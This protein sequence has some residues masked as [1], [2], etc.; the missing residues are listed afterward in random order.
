M[1]FEYLKY[2]KTQTEFKYTYYKDTFVSKVMHSTQENFS[3]CV[4][5]QYIQLLLN[6]VD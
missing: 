5:I 4:N 6:A 1:E 2:T 3:N